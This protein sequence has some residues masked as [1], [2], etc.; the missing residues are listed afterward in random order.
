MQGVLTIKTIK[1]TLIT[2]ENIDNYL[3][4]E[5]DYRSVLCY[6]EDNTINMY[7]RFQFAVDDTTNQMYMSHV[8]LGDQGPWKPYKKVKKKRYCS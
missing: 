1:M 4:E 7:S 8:M 2:R 6:M 3:R 5:E